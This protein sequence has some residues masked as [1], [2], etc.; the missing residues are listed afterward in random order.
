MTQDK[1]PRKFITQ[2]KPPKES[3]KTDDLKELYKKLSNPIE[4]EYIIEYEESGK[5][6]KG[7]NAI[8][9]V[10]RLN[11]VIGLNNWSVKSKIRKEE[12]INKSWAVAMEIIIVITY[13]KEHITRAGSGGAY[14]S[15]IENAY[16]GARTSAFK[17]ACKYLGIGKELYTNSGVDD[18]I[19]YVKEESIE[20]SVKEDNDIEIE[21][22]IDKAE[23][24]EALQN[25][26]DELEKVSA[27]YKAS[28][29][30]KYNHKKITLMTKK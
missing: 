22:K 18:D 20:T 19:V 24:V 30:K 6:F 11:E 16:K 1:Q 15:K 25:L 7:F 26:K 29:Y 17:N 21:K 4:E 9:A 14:A 13:K 27:P 3:P 12:L 28:V 10:N 8:A 5:K 23:T 2:D